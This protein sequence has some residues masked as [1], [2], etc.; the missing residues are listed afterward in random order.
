MRSSRT[1]RGLPPTT[2]TKWLPWP[3]RSPP[4]PPT[5]EPAWRVRSPSCRRSPTRRK[6]NRDSAGYR[7]PLSVLAKNKGDSDS[8]STL[9]LALV[10]ARH[11]EPASTVVY[12]PNHAFVGVAL[13][14]APGERTFTRDG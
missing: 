2:P 12:V 13:E 1:T 7:R 14:A 8:K 11:P 9:F 6:K 3:R 4:T 10:H 5:R